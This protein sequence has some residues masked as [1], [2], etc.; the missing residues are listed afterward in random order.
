MG[1]IHAMGMATARSHL[2]GPNRK[3]SIS[4]LGKQRERVCLLLSLVPLLKTL[5]DE[6]KNTALK[7]S[8][9]HFLLNSTFFVDGSF[10]ASP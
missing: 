8:T 6:C 1:S 5:Q 2:G 9:S 3:E 10:N 7:P 4:W